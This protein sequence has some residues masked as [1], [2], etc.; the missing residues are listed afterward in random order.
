M[1]CPKDQRVTLVNATLSNKLAVKL[2]P[3]CQGNW[4]SATDYEAWIASQ[5]EK[6]AEPKLMAKSTTEI[7]FV[8]S[9]NDNRAA[10]CP[11]CQHYLTRAK[12]FYKRAFYVERCTHCGGI[13]C[14]KGEWEVLEKLGLHTNIEQLFSLEWQSRVRELEYSEK[15]RQATT[16]KLGSEVAAMVFELA[17]VLEKHPNGDF[18]VAYLMRRF[19]K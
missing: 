9:P 15:E 12:V 3:D 6:T 19:H 18:G 4:I 17:E 14:D 7:N 13:W 8:P 11:E 10:L 5:S 1:Q 2:C 16:E